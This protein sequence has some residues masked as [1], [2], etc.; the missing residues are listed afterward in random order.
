MY[1]DVNGNVKSLVLL[2]GSFMTIFLNFGKMI[3]DSARD[4]NDI[5]I[6]QQGHGVTE[7]IGSP[8]SHVR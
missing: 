2:Q 4:R 1:Y 5:A 8:V 7:E 6:E 3:P